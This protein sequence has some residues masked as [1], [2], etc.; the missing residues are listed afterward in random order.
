MEDSSK[1]IYYTKAFS[2][3]R[4]ALKE[5][6]AQSH[7]YAET[8]SQM[9]HPK[10]KEQVVLVMSLGNAI[11]WCVHFHVQ[12]WSTSTW[13]MCR[14]GYVMLLNAS[15]Q[16][17]RVSDDEYQTLYKML[18]DAK[19][20]KKDEREKKTSARR[21]KNITLEQIQKIE[22]YVR[23]KPS[24]RW[25]TTLVVW[26]KAAV[27]TGL[28]PNEWR[29]AS[30]RDVDGKF[31]LTSPNFKHNEVRSFGPTRDIDLTDLPSEWKQEVKK[32][33]AFIQAFKENGEGGGAGLDWHYKGCSALLL[34]LNKRLWPK[35]KSN[36]NLYTGRHQFSANAKASESCSEL[37]R[38]ALMG[39]KTTK[40]SRE[41]YGRKSHGQQGLTPEVGDPSVLPKIKPS[42]KPLFSQKNTPK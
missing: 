3:A 28:R 20:L 42:E 10:N 31:I 24:L 18:F 38:A 8:T 36:I 23:N 6:Q 34:A 13:R 19:A 16:H 37:E 9:R 5:A 21:K 7:P 4:R 33:L 17:G 35:R 27:V 11:R 29:G 14:A 25:G 30:V 12:T 41:R 26:L 39:H 15:K 32:Q 2:N 1:L 40:T 22:D